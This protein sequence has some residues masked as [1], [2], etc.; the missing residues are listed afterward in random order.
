MSVA[1]TTPHVI[2]RA[3]CEEHDTNSA[4]H[5]TPTNE[6]ANSEPTTSVSQQSIPQVASSPQP[7][8]KLE[9]SPPPATK[10][11]PDSDNE[12]T[13]HP[14]STIDNISN[15]NS[16]TTALAPLKALPSPSTAPDLFPEFEYSSTPKIKQEEEEINLHVIPLAPTTASR[17]PRASQMPTP[18]RKLRANALNTRRTALEEVEADS[19]IDRLRRSL[20]P[21]PPPPDPTHRIKRKRPSPPSHP[22]PDGD[23]LSTTPSPRHVEAARREVISPTP[24]HRI[25]RK[26]P[27]ERIDVKG[28]H[29]VA[30]GRAGE[31]EV[32]LGVASG[33]VR[34]DEKAVASSSRVKR[35]RLSE[36]ANI[37]RVKKSFR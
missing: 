17:R 4:G 22:L 25:M 6:H 35:K 13:H 31:G 7:A 28:T 32:N 34:D 27:N 5:E 3:V 29:R 15:T 14:A 8:I 18:L 33:V 24:A 10:L 36:K 9:P 37:G 21:S 20:A 11:E 26:R 19:D 1:D 2:Q 16:H 12:G 23:D 30:W